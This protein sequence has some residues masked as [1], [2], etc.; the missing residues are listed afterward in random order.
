[1]GGEGTI[2]KIPMYRLACPRVLLLLVKA[3]RSDAWMDSLGHLSA[4]L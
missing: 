2:A 3:F 4:V 1:M